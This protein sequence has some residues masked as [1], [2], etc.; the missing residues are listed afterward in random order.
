VTG[1]PGRDELDA[2]RAQVVAACQRLRRE[3]LVV[4]TAGNVSVRVGDLVVV[5]PSG[6]DYDRLTPELVGVHTLTGEPVRA[7]L[8]PSTELPLHLAVYARHG[9]TAVVHTHAPASTAV[10]TV[11]DELPA[12]HYYTAMFGGPVRV[13]PYAT[14]GSA[15]LADHAVAALDGRHAAILGNH[16]AVTVGDDLSTALDLAGYLEYLCDVQLRAAATGRPVRTL[17]AAELDVVAGRL[18]SYRQRL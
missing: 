7:R 11:Y 18:G 5:S 6:V 4:G 15:A 16:G 14:F 3:G 8:R 12:A 13:T 2:A 1:G 17:P 10:S 9:V